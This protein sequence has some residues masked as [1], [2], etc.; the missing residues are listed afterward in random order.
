[1]AGGGAERSAVRAAAGTTAAAGMDG[2][3]ELRVPFHRTLTGQVRENP[4]K[5]ASDCAPCGLSCA[6]VYL[7]RRSR[8]L[9]RAFFTCTR[10]VL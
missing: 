8:R 5:P 10:A 1:M 9:V 7:V 2:G 6:R 3:G 4:G